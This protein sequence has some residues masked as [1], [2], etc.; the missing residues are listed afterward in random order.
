MIS[1]RRVN[2][3]KNG[4][5][6]RIVILVTTFPPQLVPLLFLAE[7]VNNGGHHVKMGSL[8]NGYPRMI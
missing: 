2:C 4:F 8:K 5:M 1:K 3:V 7:S 6:E